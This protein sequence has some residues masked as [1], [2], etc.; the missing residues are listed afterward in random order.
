M[1]SFDV[2]SLYTNIP[3]NDLLKTIKFY[4]NT[5]DQFT[6]KMGIPQGKFID[7]VHLLLTTAWYSFNSQFYQQTDDVAMG[8]PASAITAEIY[9][10]TREQTA[11]SIALHPLEVWE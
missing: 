6:R 11:I 5:D 7:L 9:L 3:I 10:Q 2:V 4:F 8:G 1:V